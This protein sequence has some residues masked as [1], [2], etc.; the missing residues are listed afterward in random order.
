MLDEAAGLDC[1]LKRF[2]DS[3]KRIGALVLSAGILAGVP[4]AWGQ[5][6]GHIQHM[7]HMP[8]TASAPAAAGSSADARE[9]VRFPDALREHTLANMRDHLLALQQIQEAL[10]RGQEDAAARIAEQRLGMSSL[11]LHEA[12]EVAKFM[13]EGMQAAGTEMHRSASRFAIEAQNTGVTSDLKPALD[14]LSKVTAACVSC[15]AAY[16]LQ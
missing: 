12:H 5:H 14:A 1:N 10:S 8:P 11:G 7:E 15:H 3:M 13:P 16:R 9:F 4:L 6:S 2:E